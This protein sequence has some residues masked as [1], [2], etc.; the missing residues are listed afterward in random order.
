MINYIPVQN[1][2]WQNIIQKSRQYIDNFKEIQ[3]CRTTNLK[4]NMEQKLLF[5]DIISNVNQY[6]HKYPDVPLIYIE[7]QCR[8]YD[9]PVYLIAKPI[10]SETQYLVQHY[11]L[12][13]IVTGEE[14]Y[15][16]K[17]LKRLGYKSKLSNFMNL[18]RVKINK[19]KAQK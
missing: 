8:R 7:S 16:K 3:K 13:L 9:I 14:K 15:Y 6:C 1:T 19:S 4:L 11:H 12:L 10:K 2:I 5:E 17:E 18:G